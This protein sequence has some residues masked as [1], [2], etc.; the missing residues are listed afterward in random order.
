MSKIER[1]EAQ[2]QHFQNACELVEHNS[3]I[4]KYVIKYVELDGFKSDLAVLFC[5]LEEIQK[6]PETYT[7]D[8]NDRLY[9]INPSSKQ[10]FL[11]ANKSQVKV[12]LSLIHI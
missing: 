10:P 9:C 5:L 3:T 12:S 11:G 2:P 8:K 4:R 1:I 7:L 6:S